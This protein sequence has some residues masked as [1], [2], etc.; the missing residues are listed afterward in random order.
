MCGITGYIGN[1][2]EQAIKTS[3][4]S[5]AHRGPDA[6]DVFIEEDVT[7]AH[8]RLSIIDLSEHA[9]QPFHFEYLT[10]VF[11]G[12]LYNYEKVR[13]ELE[14]EGYTFTTNSD[15]EVLIKSFHRWGKDCINRFI[16]MFA[17]AMYD[18]RDKSVYLCRD[19]VGVK[20]TILHP[21]RR[22]GIWKRNEVYHAPVEKQGDRP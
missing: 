10:L 1:F 14:K 3:M 17:F 4:E 5:I 21:G 13:T 20:T 19:R 7:L 11:N 22:A 2:N 15:T 6:F 9:N 8:R 12:E 16:G 18:K